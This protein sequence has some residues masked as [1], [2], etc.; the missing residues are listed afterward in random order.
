M[1]NKWKVLPLFCL[2]LMVFSFS[3]TG[4]AEVVKPVSRGMTGKRA[5][6][7]LTCAKDYLTTTSTFYTELSASLT[8][9]AA[10][11][12]S[13][14]VYSGLP[15]FP[16]AS[17]K[18]IQ[19]LESINSKINR[20]LNKGVTK[21][22]RKLLLYVQSCIQG[23]LT[24]IRSLGTRPVSSSADYVKEHMKQVKPQAKKIKEY[25]QRVGSRY[26]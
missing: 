7:C 5:V 12:G 15:G 21:R 26:Y 18:A 13:T 25:A 17:G 19:R 9:G 14:T 10:A 6:K 11:V 23:E 20:L 24:F 3:V 4:H 22:G 2:L 1:K 16:A 8:S